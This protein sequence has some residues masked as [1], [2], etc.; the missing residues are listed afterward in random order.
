M[1]L[2][3]SANLA[4]FG[5]CSNGLD[6]IQCGVKPSLMLGPTLGLLAFRRHI[7]SLL[8]E[9]RKMRRRRCPEA[10]EAWEVALLEQ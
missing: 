7:D 5:R 8:A 1:G 9:Q 2:R 4:D 6:F 3:R 10:G